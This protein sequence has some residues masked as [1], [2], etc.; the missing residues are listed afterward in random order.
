VSGR[1]TSRANNLAAGLLL[2]HEMFNFG[3]G[4]DIPDETR[5]P[6]VEGPEVV[7]QAGLGYE[8]RRATAF[9]HVNSL[10]ILLGYPSTVAKRLLV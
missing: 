1:L 3:M 8:H 4:A 5:P 10:T 7:S 9:P 2:T 6:M